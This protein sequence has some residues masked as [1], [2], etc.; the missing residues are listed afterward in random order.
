[1]EYIEYIFEKISHIY[2]SFD[3]RNNFC[4]LAKELDEKYKW[5]D[6][7][8]AR[9]NSGENIIKDIMTDEDGAS[10]LISTK[11]RRWIETDIGQSICK[12]VIQKN[13]VNQYYANL[14]KNDYINNKI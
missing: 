5:W 3:N 2:S 13:K 9:L 6:E 7:N 1:M 4:D 10:L 14:K 8:N 12:S 11:C